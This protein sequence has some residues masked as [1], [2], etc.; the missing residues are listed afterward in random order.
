MVA[1]GF[2]AQMHAEKENFN[3]LGKLFGEMLLRPLMDF[4]LGRQGDRL[5]YLVKPPDPKREKNPT[6]RA[7]DVSPSKSPPPPPPPPPPPTSVVGA[8]SHCVGGGNK[9]HTVLRKPRGSLSSRTRCNCFACF[10]CLC[11]PYRS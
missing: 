4:G 3:L 5:A 8:W 1:L 6:G 2:R 7:D 11:T 9:V 10:R